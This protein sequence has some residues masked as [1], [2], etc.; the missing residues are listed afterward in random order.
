MEGYSHAILYL[1]DPQYLGSGMTPEC[2]IQVEELI[3]NLP[4]SCSEPSTANWQEALFSDF[5]DFSIAA[6]E[7]K[8]QNTSVYCMIME[9]KLSV[10]KFRLSRDDVWPHLQQLAKKIFG[11]VASSAASER[12]L[13]A[14]GFVHSN[15]RNSLSPAA[16]EKLV[17]VKT[18]NLQFTNQSHISEVDEDDED[19]KSV[20]LLESQGRDNEDD[21]TAAAAMD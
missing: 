14:F 20:E 8:N 16:V 3:F 13:S 10:L 7:M 18:I 15:L 4:I 2:R 5:T 1:L 9:R 17:Y 12:N 11:L 19:D 6:Q 21:N